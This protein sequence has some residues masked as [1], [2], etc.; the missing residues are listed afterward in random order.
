M[1][2]KYRTKVGAEQLLLVLFVGISVY[3]FADSFSF[4]PDAA[5]FPQIM[6]ASVIGMGLLLLFRNF[7]PENVQQYLMQEQTIDM[8]GSDEDGI[9]SEVNEAG[10]EIETVADTLDRPLHPTTF[11]GV[12]VVL[13]LVGSYAFGIFWATPVFVVGYLWWFKQRPLNIVI[14]TTISMIAVYGFIEFLN[15]PF[16]SGELF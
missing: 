9:A 7:L 1:L 4:H 12:A 15:M 10:E 6:S 3:M 16:M 14:V 2:E 13:Y 8:G 5:K 11:T